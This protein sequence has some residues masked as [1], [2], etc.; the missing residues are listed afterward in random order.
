MRERI[1][2][3]R[4]WIKHSF[5]DYPG[6]IATALFLGGC[7]LRCPYCHNPHLV[8]IKEGD[9][10][11]SLEEILSY[12]DRRKDIIEG[13]VISGGEPTIHKDQLPQIVKLI[14]EK[15]F[16]I[17]LDTN[18]L[19][20]E[21]I[22]TITPDYCA[23]DLKTL[24]SRYKE[25]GWNQDSCEKLLLRA[26]SIIKEMGEKGEVRITV[27]PPF[28]GESEIV[29][30]TKVLK[31]VKRVFLQLFSK[32]TPLLDPQMENCEIVEEQ[33]LNKYKKILL[34]SVESCEIRG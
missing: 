18:G 14:R 23:L 21:M 11:F 20:P 32:Q 28:V 33:V 24:P 4:G 3:I 26:I 34:E 10:S 12:L 29:W 9:N 30:F 1:T 17:K 5:I 7:N 13:I 25:L 16:K 19:I 27:V 2:C 22:E 31:G 15:G 6:K 8:E